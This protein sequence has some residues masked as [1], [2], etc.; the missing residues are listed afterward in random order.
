MMV[1]ERTPTNVRED[2]TEGLTAEASDLGWSPG[3]WPGAFQLAEDH[4]ATTFT[5]E[6]I[7]WER[8]IPRGYH[9]RGYDGRRMKVF[10][11]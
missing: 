8:G 11:D 3:S 5:R 1:I 4:G 2:A 7:I 10:N 9:Y 6:Q